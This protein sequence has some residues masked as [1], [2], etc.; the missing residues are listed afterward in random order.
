M[1]AHRF[2][3]AGASLFALLAAGGDTGAAVG[4]WL[5]GFIADTLG[6]STALSPLRTALL[7]GTLYPLAMIVCLLVIRK[8]EMESQTLTIPS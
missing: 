3:L 6:Q 1:A 4:P 5:V 7:T 8:K 2:P